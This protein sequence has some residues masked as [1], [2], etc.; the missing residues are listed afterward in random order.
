MFCVF[1]TVKRVF[2][3][4]APKGGWG[5]AVPGPARKAYRERHRRRCPQAGRRGVSAHPGF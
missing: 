2:T 4:N 5:R 1:Y 3:G